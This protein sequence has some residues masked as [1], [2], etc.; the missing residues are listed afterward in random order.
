MTTFVQSY[1]H[2]MGDFSFHTGFDVAPST[3]SSGCLTS[4]PSYR[5]GGV[6]SPAS[7]NMTFPPGMNHIPDSYFFNEAISNSPVPT[8]MDYSFASCSPRTVT[9]PRFP[10]D[11]EPLQA[12]ANQQTVTGS[13]K[14]PYQPQTPEYLPDVPIKLE[15]EPPEPIKDGLKGGKRGR[16]PR[17]RKG[18][19]KEIK[20]E[21]SDSEVRPRDPRRRRILERNRI[22][23]TKCRMRKRDEATALATREQ[24]MEEHNR[25][26]SRTF[27]ELTTEI[28]HLKTQLLRHTDCGCT[29][30][31]QFI[32]NEARK[33]VKDLPPCISPLPCNTMPMVGSQSSSNGSRASISVA[34]V[35]DSYGIR[36]PDMEPVSS[37]PDDMFDMTMEPMQK[38]HILMS[39]HAIPNMHSMHEPFY[40]VQWTGT[41]PPFQV[42]EDGALWGAN[43]DFR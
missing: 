13:Q 17:Q 9:A 1:P 19:L 30:I 35:T 20:S 36:T 8:Q 41:G 23:A 31:Q 3:P 12:K 11:T 38:E 22:A 2:P 26:L 33:S 24:E 5:I 40:P 18:S 34:S 42:I 43:W 39:S 15:E 4:P 29:L 32:A 16:K 25:Q 28:Y 37:S 21:D 7:R 10:Q 27:D 6:D 14:T